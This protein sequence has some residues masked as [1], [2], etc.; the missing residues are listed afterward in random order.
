MCAER[1]Q[2][3][4]LNIFQCSPSASACQPVSD[5]TR[6]RGAIRDDF[7]LKLGFS[8]KVGILSPRGGMQTQ[9]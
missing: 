7:R 3:F 2:D 8:V 9:V 1:E 5:A 4:S 6:V